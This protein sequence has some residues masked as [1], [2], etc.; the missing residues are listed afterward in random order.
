ML[1]ALEEQFPPSSRTP[2]LRAA[3]PVPTLEPVAGVLMFTL[4]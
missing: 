4:A 2:P 3:D 1:L